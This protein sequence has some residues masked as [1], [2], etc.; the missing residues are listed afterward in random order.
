MPSSS[1]VAAN[2]EVKRVIN[3]SN[4]NPV[5]KHG[6][7]EH[8]TSEEKAMIA[9]QAAEYGVTASV[10][11]FSK[12]FPGHSLKE[13]SVQTWK[14][15]YLQ[16]IAARKRA[17][18]DAMVKELVPKKTGRPLMLGEDLDRLDNGKGGFQAG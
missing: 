13:S 8:F 3:Q 12:L 5:S 9:K 10:R 16:E 14:M 4:K 11:H 17:G 7:C 1:I 15:K 2:K 6:A 18:E